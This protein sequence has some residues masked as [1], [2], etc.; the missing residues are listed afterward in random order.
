MTTEPIELTDQ[1][2]DESYDDDINDGLYVEENNG[3]VASH[4]GRDQVQ[5]VH[6]W[7]G[8]YQAA[9]ELSDAFV[10][11]TIAN[12]VERVYG[13]NDLSRESAARI[14]QE[15]RHVLLVADPGT[16]RRTAAVGLLGAVPSPR[17]EIPTDDDQQRLLPVGEVP[18]T[19]Y[20][21][22]S[23]LLTV[24]PGS[25]NGRLREVLIAYREEVEKQDSYLVV[26]VDQNTL[27]NPE[28]VP[29][30]TVLTVTAP[31]RE[32]LLRRLLADQHARLDVDTLLRTP[33]LP[34][35]LVDATPAQIARL[36][37]RIRAAAN[38]S[39]EPLAEIARKAVQ[40]Y[41]N[42][43]KELGDWFENNADPRTRLF[44]VA[45]AFLQGGQATNV[46][47]AMERLA[48]K[49]AEP[50]NVRGGIG[51]PGIR[52]LA[53][54]V[55]ARID[56]QHRIFFS[57]PSYDVAILRYVHG[58]Q[59]KAFRTRLWS[60]ASDLP[61][62]RG[63]SPSA[64]IAGRV[65]SAMLDVTRALPGADAPE[66]RTLAERWWSYQSLR[67]LVVDLMT[68]VALSPE[69]GP[70][71]RGRLNQW[72]IH[73]GSH[74]LLCAVAEVCGGALADAYPQAAL[75]RLNNLAGRGIGAV[76]DAVVAAVRELWE[77]SM[78]RQATLCRVVDWAAE[79][80]QRHDVGLRALATISATPEQAGLLLTELAGD[81][82]LHGGLADAFA[83]L[84]TGAGP[85]GDFR[86]ALFN[87]LDAA[88]G[89]STY[90]HLFTDLLIRAGG[91]GQGASK[92]LGR[93]FDLLYDWQPVARDADAPAARDLRDRVQEQ[94]HRANPL[95]VA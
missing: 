65:A 28:E 9:R 14:L 32:E 58:D 60:W 15:R 11:E 73:S 47:H 42:W 48:E 82:D 74:P 46:L 95:A 83:F 45:L 8:R 70:A 13:P 55:G 33:P 2:I 80:D 17:R 5:N 53:K 86:K 21:R 89:D 79:Q 22:C 88:A 52:Q 51:A 38:E 75:T 3:L 18:W 76:T 20:G 49:L 64:R 93:M 50:A 30:F 34:A 78:H 40:A 67:P 39:Q 62:R 26:L 85:Q 66:V 43:D 31:G 94:L 61:M 84:F 68:A 63:G 29:G 44:L 91:T 81:A 36:S 23:Y 37:S 90:E 12:F 72:A 19:S 41:Q 56:D 10:R 24:P 27:E 69:A 59:S 92:R 16:G 4:V 54:N 1:D 57:L 25:R 71:M 35:M 87:W 77:R 7:L 6:N